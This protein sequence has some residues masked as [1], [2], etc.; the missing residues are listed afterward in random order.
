MKIKCLCKQ[1]KTVIILVI[2]IILA[3]LF[4]YLQD[5]VKLNPI[6]IAGLTALFYLALSY[7]WDNR[8]K[9]WDKRAICGGL[10]L[11]VCF[12]LMMVTG[13]KINVANGEFLPF[14]IIDFFKGIFYFII[15][16]IIFSFFFLL[17]TDKMVEKKLLDGRTTHFNLKSFLGYSLIL[18]LSWIPIFLVYYPGIIPGDATNSIG[19]LMGD[20][21]WSNHFPV[22]YTLIIGLFLQI[23]EL[24]GNINLG[25]ALYSITQL[26]TMALAIG[27]MLEWL[28]RRGVCRIWIYMCV[29]YFSAIPLFGNYAIVMWKDPWF[30]AALIF[31]CIFLYDNVVTDPEKFL[32]KKQLVLYAAIVILSCLL[33]NNG[34]YIAALLSAFLLIIY[35]HSMRKVCAGILIPLVIVLLITGPVYRSVFSAENVFAESVGIPLQQMARTVVMEGKMTKEQKEVLDA[36][37]PL[38]EYKDLYSPFVVDPIKWAQDFDNEYLEAHKIDFLKTWAG[39]MKSNFGEYVK[40][41]LMGTYGFWH[42]GGDLDYEFVKFAIPENNWGIGQSYFFENHFDYSIQD[43]LNPR[44]DYL[45]SGIL[46]WILFWDIVMCWMKKKSIYI[47]PLLAMAGNWITLL[48]ATPI[49]FG[50]RYLFVCVIGLPILLLYPW[51]IQGQMNLGRRLK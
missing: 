6:I 47:I 31:L 34:I 45:P 22:F 37:L 33:R 18:I 50:I 26:I 9:M 20:Q 42:I 23:G 5:S 3:N 25:V 17:G 46:V 35:R 38:E 39:M 11:A 8:E 29:G 28:R 30:S 14:A 44:Y 51:L 21:P 12:S 2:S 27:F 13:A 49:A 19:M 32:Q 24:T 16:E 41:Y 4:I 15:G 43:K 36:I 7:V 1:Y 40:Q 48:V 10:L